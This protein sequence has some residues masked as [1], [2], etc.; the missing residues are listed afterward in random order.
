M[1]GGP[2]F[3]VRGRGELRRPISRFSRW[4]WCEE[5]V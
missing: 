3:Q 4:L 2:M 5:A 1:V